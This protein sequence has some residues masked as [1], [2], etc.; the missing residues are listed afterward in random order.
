MKATLTACLA[1]SKCYPTFEFQIAGLQMFPQPCRQ[2]RLGVAF[3]V[4]QFFRLRFCSCAV[5][6][7]RSYTSLSDKTHGVEVRDQGHA[8]GEVAA[9]D[10][11][12][13]RKLPITVV[14]PTL[15]EAAQIHD[16]VAA[17]AWADEVIVVDGGSKDGTAELARAAGATVIKVT[18]RTIGAQ[19]NVGIA[20]ARNAWVLALDADERVPEALQAELVAVLA[21]P[22]HSAYRIP[23]KHIYLGK[24]LRHG[25]WGRDWHVRLFTREGRFTENRVHEQ[26]E[27]PG[28]VGTL[29][30]PLVHTPYRDLNHHLE[31]IIRYARW[32]AED[33]RARGRR[34]NVGDVTVVPL[35]RFLREYVVYSGWRDGQRGLV[36]AT[37]G[38][39]AALLKFAHLFAMEWQG[40]EPV[41]RESALANA[42]YP[43]KTTK[44]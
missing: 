18:G 27:S 23:F 20:A 40:Q 34:P 19:R 21:S 43:E 17:L 28:D 42:P 13:P 25:G 24:E 3:L 31:K 6:R 9:S 41:A 2:R 12:K 33:L 35:W 22:R 15:N 11:P 32:G 29:S 38:G 37:L 8:L 30:A 10:R 26:L 36:A 5:R 7:L 1:Q 44:A 39:C 14:T 4:S 16:A